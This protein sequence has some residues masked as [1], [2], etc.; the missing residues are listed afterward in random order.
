VY[1]IG[2]VEVHL[3]IQVFTFELFINYTFCG[4]LLELDLEK[5][6]TPEEKKK[7]YDA[8]GYEGEDTSTSSYPEDVSFCTLYNQNKIYIEYFSSSILIYLFI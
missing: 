8:I 6:M 2:G 5:V 3:K 4:D 7:L 1:R